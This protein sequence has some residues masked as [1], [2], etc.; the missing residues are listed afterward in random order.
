ME[1]PDHIKVEITKSAIDYSNN[2][3]RI[4][5]LKSI[6]SFA[7]IDFKQGAELGYS[8]SQDEITRLNSIITQF[9]ELRTFFKKGSP[10]TEMMDKIIKE[11]NL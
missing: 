10:L 8:L 7:I 6:I 4:D 3:L 1:L 11:N 2:K 9:K 5:E